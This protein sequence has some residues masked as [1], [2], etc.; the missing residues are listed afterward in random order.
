M[1]GGQVM[2]LAMGGEQV[3]PRAPQMTLD[4]RPVSL[5]LP[6]GEQPSPTAGQLPLARASTAPG[7][8]DEE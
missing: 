8:P 4:N 5:A 2:P 6:V 1:L 3:S 7:R